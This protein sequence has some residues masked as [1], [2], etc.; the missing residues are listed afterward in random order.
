MLYIH[1]PNPLTLSLH[2]ILQQSH[3]FK[4]RKDGFALTPIVM[5]S[6]KKAAVKYFVDPLSDQKIILKDMVDLFEINVVVRLLFKYFSRDEVH[7]SVLFGA[8]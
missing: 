5:F 4:D 2:F 3:F 6:T 8:D 1:Y 7:D